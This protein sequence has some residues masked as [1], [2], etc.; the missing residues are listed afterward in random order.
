MNVDIKAG[1]VSDNMKKY[2]N[3]EKI[4]IHKENTYRSK[5]SLHWF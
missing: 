2:K 1:H 5:N 3:I 4:H